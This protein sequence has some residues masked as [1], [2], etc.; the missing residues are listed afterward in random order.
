MEE[1]KTI[2]SMME[3]KRVFNP[4]EQIRQ[5]AYIKSLDEYKRIYQKSVDDP[6]GF[7]GELAN[8]HTS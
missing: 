6:E 4:P 5:N 2:T 7:W 3:E 1:A 8:L